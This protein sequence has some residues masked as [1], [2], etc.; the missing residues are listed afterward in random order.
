[1]T[2]KQEKIIEAGLELF[3]QEGY[4]ATSTNKV[5][6][7]AGVSEGLIFRHFIN[8]EGL[9]K[10]IIKFGEERVGEVFAVTL[11]EKDPKKLLKNVISWPFQMPED[12]MEFWKLQF[13]LKWELNYSNPDKLKPLI[14]ALTNAFEALNYDN[15]ALEAAFISHLLEG[16]F[17]ALIR[18]EMKEREQFKNFIIKKYNL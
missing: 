17:T 10:A 5:A 13:K 4:A 7:R 16:V 3:A 12:E 11:S 8:K 2:E 9:L 1:M 14:D 18:G 15:P 6:K